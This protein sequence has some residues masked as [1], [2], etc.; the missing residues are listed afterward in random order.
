MHAAH[1]PAAYS[2]FGWRSVSFPEFRKCHAT[3]AFEWYDCP[4]YPAEYSGNASSNFHWALK[5]SAE[6]HWSAPDCAGSGKR[7]QSDRR[8][9]TSEA[10][11]LMSPVPGR[12]VC[13]D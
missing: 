13:L 1:E 11:P 7:P 8:T 4:V 3:A 2:S 5:L 10:G 12:F 6:H 9:K